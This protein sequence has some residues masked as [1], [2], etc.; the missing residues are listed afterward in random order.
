MDGFN[1]R[2]TCPGLNKSDLSISEVILLIQQLVPVL[3]TKIRLKTQAR[4]LMTIVH[5]AEGDE[6]G[7]RV[8]ARRF[9]SCVADAVTVSP[10]AIRN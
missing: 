7:S 2:T 5:E 3:W 9:S 1:D 8:L 4:I 10:S 6:W